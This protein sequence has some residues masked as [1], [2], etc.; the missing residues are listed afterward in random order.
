VPRGNAG[1]AEYA[2]LAKGDEE[3]G[4]GEGCCW[5]GGG[6]RGAPPVKDEICVDCGGTAVFERVL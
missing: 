5:C 6:G 2:W 4:N 3:T 1:F